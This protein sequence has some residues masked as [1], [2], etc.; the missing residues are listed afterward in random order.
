MSDT[1]QPP[2]PIA[3]LRLVFTAY[4]GM[5]IGLGVVS[6]LVAGGGDAEPLVFVVA[7][8]A[9]AVAGSVL[10]GTAGTLSCRDAA[11]LISSYRTRFFL[12]LAVAEVPVLVGFAATFLVEPW[13]IYLVGVG[14][15]VPG[16]VRASPSR[17]RLVR[18]QERLQLEGCP[19]DLLEL[20][21]VRSIGP[22][23]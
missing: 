10:A 13:W 19:H 8:V 4:L 23:G 7:I 2:P 18:D 15:A 3:V 12:R 17:S 6:A 22:V 1:P 21:G 20:L 11:S 16:F 14:V 9:I 5:V